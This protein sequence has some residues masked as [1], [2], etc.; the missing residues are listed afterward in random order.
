MPVTCQ[1]PRKGRFR[2]STSPGIFD[3][4]IGLFVTCGMEGLI[5]TP[6]S[7]NVFDEGG[8]SC[9]LSAY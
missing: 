1:N 2:A 8:G 4:G 9:M 7:A 5:V 6:G 3:V